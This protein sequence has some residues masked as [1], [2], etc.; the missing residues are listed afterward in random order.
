MIIGP[1]KMIRPNMKG[2][3]VKRLLGAEIWANWASYNGRPTELSLWRYMGFREDK[4]VVIYQWQS[5][6]GPYAML[7]GTYQHI[8]K[9][10]DLFRPFLIDTEDFLGED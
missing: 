3:P 6:E 4:G 8:A 1:N 9:N 7:E 10:K 5:I 2:K